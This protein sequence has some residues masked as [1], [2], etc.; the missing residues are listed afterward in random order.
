MSHGCP[1]A[2]SNATCLPEV[3]QDAALYFDPYDPKDIAEKVKAIIDQPK[4]AKDL[5]AKG[6][7]VLKQY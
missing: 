1:V 3:Y 6:N 5:V 7:K 4:L 2:S